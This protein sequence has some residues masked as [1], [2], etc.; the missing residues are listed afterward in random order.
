MTAGTLNEAGCGSSHTA[1]CHFFKLQIHTY[2]GRRGTH[3]HLLTN[4]THDF[5]DLDFLFDKIRLKMYS[6][7][8]RSKAN[9][10][11]STMPFGAL[12]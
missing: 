4:D 5:D 1:K 10:F 9:S 7:L 12:G 6:F 2:N 11:L 8:R 3:I